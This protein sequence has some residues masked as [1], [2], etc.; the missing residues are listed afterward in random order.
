MIKE[1]KKEV[2][3]KKLTKERK[4]LRRKWTGNENMKGKK[5]KIEVS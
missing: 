1:W 5:E 3:E 2:M 4:D